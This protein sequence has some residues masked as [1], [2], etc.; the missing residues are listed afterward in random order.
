MAQAVFAHEGAAIDYTPGADVSAGDVIVQGD[1]VGVARLDIKAG[2]LGA[3]AVTGVFDFPKATGVGTA[4]AAGV[5][6]YWD[7]ADAEAKTDSETGA[8]K[9]IGKTVAAAG[10]NDATVRVRMSQ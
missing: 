3:L 4:I 10:D 7:V 8:N 1:L 9:L 6:V 5:E 2:V